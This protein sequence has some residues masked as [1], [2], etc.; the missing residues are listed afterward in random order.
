[1]KAITD[2]IKKKS[3]RY[4]T[5]RNEKG[6][7]SN[8]CNSIVC[9]LSDV[10]DWIL[11]NLVDKTRTRRGV[12]KKLKDMGI[13]FKAPTKRSTKAALAGKNLWQPEEDEQLSS[14]YDQHRMEPGT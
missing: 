2:K 3:K 6:K 9:A 7:P 10:I 1:M 12:L 8:N 5:K 4:E 14:L 13:H 11:D